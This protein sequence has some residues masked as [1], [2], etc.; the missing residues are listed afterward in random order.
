[1][2]KG[3]GKGKGKKVEGLKKKT[4]YVSKPVLKKK[5]VVSKLNHG[6]TFYS[7]ALSRCHSNCADYGDDDEC[8]EL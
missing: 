1:M 4:G 7:H 5:T 3:K 8:D 2:E 6:D